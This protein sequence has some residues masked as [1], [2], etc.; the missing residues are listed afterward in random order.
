[1]ILNGRYNS[2]RTTILTSNFTL[3]APEIET[4]KTF[5]Q[6]VL[7]DRVGARIASRIQEMCVT[8]S[9]EGQDLRQ[10]RRA[11]NQ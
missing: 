3:A 10:K 7:P 2:R 9:M 8:V 5:R 6:E 11:V 4:G 1:L